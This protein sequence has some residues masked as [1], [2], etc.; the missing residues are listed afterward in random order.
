[1]RARI[2]ELFSIPELYIGKISLFQVWRVL[3]ILA[4]G[5][6][7]WFCVI[8]GYQL[9]HYLRLGSCAEAKVV[10]WNVKELDSSRFAI[11]S[12]FEFQVDGVPYQ[13]KSL[14]T[15]PIY[16]N[17]FAAD[18]AIKL[19]DKEALFVWYQASNPLISS[20]SKEFPLKS[21][22]HALLTLGVLLYFLSIPRLR[23]KVMDS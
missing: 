10:A 17:P 9:Y 4:A 2:K 20:L 3:V 22:L 16:L 13:G 18:E 21:F 6:A 11:E 12:I 23:G 7:L 15:S 5:V 8:A 1:M 19:R 14:L